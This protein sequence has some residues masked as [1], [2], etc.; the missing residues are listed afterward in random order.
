MHASDI[1]C[2]ARVYLYIC[3][4]SEKF[5]NKNGKTKQKISTKK[6]KKKNFERSI[7]LQV[8]KQLYDFLFVIHCLYVFSIGKD[9]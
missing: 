8:L 2:H 9:F 1:R 7:P 5:N 3:C 6:T 4:E